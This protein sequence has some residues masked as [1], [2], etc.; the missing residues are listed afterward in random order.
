MRI[1]RLKSGKDQSF[2]GRAE[3]ARI[4]HS[5][6]NPYSRNPRP[7]ALLNGIVRPTTGGI[8]EGKIHREQPA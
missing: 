3:L 4:S 5:Q 6:A 8:G 1:E 2:G 7:T